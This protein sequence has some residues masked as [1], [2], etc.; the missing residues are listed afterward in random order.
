MSAGIKAKFSF[1]PQSKIEFTSRYK[2]KRYVVLVDKR[3]CLF[4]KREVELLIEYGVARYSSTNGYV[5]HNEC[6]SVVNN[7][8]YISTLADRI[9]K[10][11]GDDS[12]L[13]CGNQC[14]FLPFSKENISFCRGL[15]EM[16]ELNPKVIAKLSNVIDNL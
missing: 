5:R 9:R 15:L 4:P 6:L 3:E 13:L 2:G 10:N 7:P 1:T 12:F 8:G 11:F 16:K 14:Y